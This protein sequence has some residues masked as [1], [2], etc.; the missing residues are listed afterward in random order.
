MPNV[1]AVY[2]VFFFCACV[3]DM[4]CMCI[5]IRDINSCNLCMWT[6]MSHFVFRE[7]PF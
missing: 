7:M 1:V 6:I 5:Q 2:R 3:D 4:L